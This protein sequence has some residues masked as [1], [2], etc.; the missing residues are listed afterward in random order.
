MWSFQNADLII[1]F[2]WSNFSQIVCRRKWKILRQAYKA[3]RIWLLQ[4]LFLLPLPCGRASHWKGCKCHILNFSASF[5]F[6]AWAGDWT[7]CLMGNF[8][9]R[10]PCLLKGHMWNEVVLLFFTRCGCTCM[11]RNNYVAIQKRD[12]VDKP[13]MIQQKDKKIAGSLLTTSNHGT[14]LGTTFLWTSCCVR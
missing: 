8:G 9:E 13:R 7:G 4:A 1:L 11:W 12:V 6:R 14:Y 5:A 2:L 3:F 10:F